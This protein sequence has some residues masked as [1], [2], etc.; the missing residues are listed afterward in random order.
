MS[1][2]F[3]TTNGNQNS[4]PES[5]SSVNIA[6][7]I[8]EAQRIVTRR[9]QQ[10][11]E[12]EKNQRQ[13]IYET[14][15]DNII[16]G[17]QSIGSSNTTSRTTT[18]TTTIYNTRLDKDYSP[19]SMRKSTLVVGHSN[20][21]T[22]DEDDN[23]DTKIDD[24]FENSDTEEVNIA[25]PSSSRLKNKTEMNHSNVEADVEETNYYIR[26]DS[27]IKKFNISNSIHNVSI[28]FLYA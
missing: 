19:L 3:K 13:K 23:D 6:T 7:E 17:K 1:S 20:N 11:R 16:S 15:K 22:S 26:P 25:S 5:K 8:L 21:S 4:D 28:F 18:T 9:L 27:S 10:R 14:T 2:P 12:K 24:S